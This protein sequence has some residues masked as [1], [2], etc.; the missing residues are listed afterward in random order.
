MK[1]SLRLKDGLFYAVISYKDEFGK[2]KQKWISTNLKERG[3]KKQAQKILEQEL[4]NFKSSF[5]ENN[6]ENQITDNDVIFMNYIKTYIDE[7]ES[8]LSPS[9][10]SRYLSLWIQMKKFFGF[11]LKLKDVTYKHL[12]SFYDYLRNEKGLKNV[13]IRKYN[14]VLSPA[15]RLAYRDNLIPKNPYEFMPKIKREKSKKNFYDIDELEK[16]LP[17]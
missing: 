9:T 15:L 1:G 14:E 5:N 10:I 17:L 12:L 6:N 16:F 7:K 2:F 4:E 13:S 11:N 8:S 3:N